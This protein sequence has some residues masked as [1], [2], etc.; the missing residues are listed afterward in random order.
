MRPLQ[1]ILRQHS[2]ERT[3][4]GVALNN[5]RTDYDPNRGITFRFDV[6]P[7]NAKFRFTYSICESGNFSNKK[8][9]ELVDELYANGQGY[10]IDYDQRRALVEN[11]AHFLV[12]KLSQ[13]SLDS[14]LKNLTDHLEHCIYTNQFP[15]IKVMP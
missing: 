5:A 11:V 8:G 14:D 4:Q 2:F 9:R 12:S 6:D 3:E 10:E 13:N 15:Q 7:A 1:I